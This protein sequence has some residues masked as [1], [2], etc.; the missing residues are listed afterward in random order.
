[1]SMCSNGYGRLPGRDGIAGAGL[2]LLWCSH[3][4][5]E[6]DVIRF[7]VLGGL[8]AVGWYGPVDLGPR[9]HQKLLAVLLVNADQVVPDGSL[10]D[11]LWS[12]APPASAHRQITNS[13]ATIRRRLHAAGA[14]CDVIVRTPG[15]LRLRRGPGVEIDLDDLERLQSAADRAFADGDARGGARLLRDAVGCWRGPTLAGLDGNAIRTV[16]AYF[17]ERR[18]ALL[19]QCLTAELSHVLPET[20]IAELASLTAEHPFRERFTAQLMRALDQAGRRSEALA[21]YRMLDSRLRAELGVEPHAEVADLHR[22]ILRGGSTSAPDARPRIAAPRMLPADIGVFEGRRD[23]LEAMDRLVDTAD[24]PP[25]VVIGGMGGVGKT[26]LALRWAH[27]AT[28][29]FPDGQLY[30]NLRG[31]DRFTG[32]TGAQALGQML[33]ALG[34]SANAIPAD[35]SLAA[36]LY[37]SLIADRQMVVVLDNARSVDDVR[38]LLPAGPANVTIVTSRDSLAGLAVR[39]GA[40]LLSLA[41]FAPAES[42]ALLAR[43]L[44]RGGGPSSEDLSELAELCGH[45]P[46]ALRIAA[47][48]LLAQ[49]YRDHEEVLDALRAGVSGFE[50]HGDLDSTLGVVFDHSYATLAPHHATM[51]RLLAVTP[52]LDFSAGSAAAVAD[53]DPGAAAG[54]LAALGAAHMLID[55]GDGRMGFH[56]LLRDFATGRAVAVEVMEAM[57]RYTDWAVALAHHTD[58]V[59]PNCRAA[60]TM[61]APRR[62]LSP[63]SAPTDPALLLGYTDAELP[64]LTAAARFAAA[65]GQPD[66]GWQI[67]CLLEA[68]LERGRNVALTI[69]LAEVGVA[70]AVACADSVAER[71]TR[72]RLGVYLFQAGRS[73]AAVEHLSRAADLARAQGDP[74]AEAAALNNLGVAYKLME[75]WDA[76]LDIFARSLA[77][78][79]GSEQHRSVCALLNN[80]GNVHAQLGKFDLARSY[81]DQALALVDAEDLDDF[82]RGMTFTNLAALTIQTGQFDDAIT[83]ATVAIS[84]ASRSGHRRTAIVARIGLANAQT[85]VG[86]PRAALATLAVALDLSRVMSAQDQEAVVLGRMANAYLAIGSVNEARRCL[87]ESAAICPF[88]PDADESRLRDELRAG[89]TT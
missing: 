2:S 47:A 86:D 64:N 80:L 52:A 12:E 26:A 42:H 19:E 54:A 89:L 39:D 43:L 87:E 82:P 79:E 22:A 62:P 53:V 41:P 30:V 15:G 7:S 33:A 18:L 58:T 23:V 59:F 77:L 83:F 37:R 88:L 32:L 17:D 25:V 46:L 71:R 84:C 44:G 65:A 4:R 57:V 72:N 75:E 56:D 68:Y 35:E 34:M 24:G 38:P 73:P 49:P 20:L 9:R 67:F 66:A 13:V 50:V 55:L 45:L 78:R 5:P 76:A 21:A 3:H 70:A 29:R 74:D 61:S 1:M 81:L 6:A 69:E 85:A 10:V 27:A 16:A 60:A 14:P 31:Y 11:A 8:A 63:G 36:A 51:F 28:A 40:G 48:A